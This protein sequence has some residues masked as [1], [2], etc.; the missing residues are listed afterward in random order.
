MD[1]EVQS[2]ESKKRFLKRY[3]KNMSK[4]ERLQAKLETIED[5][6][7]AISSPGFSDMPRGTNRITT[8]DRIHEK[9]EL[10]QRIERLTKRGYDLKAEILEVIDD[11]EE[12]REAEVLELFCIDG[13][14]FY[15][16]A[17]ELHYTIRHVGRLYNAA[18][19]NARIPDDNGKSMSF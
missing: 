8:A 12:P 10:E 1:N 16:I 15:D 11:L 9:I 4:V 3:R 6:L 17:D 2:I 5:R 7:S 19:R 18:I 14:D 13:L